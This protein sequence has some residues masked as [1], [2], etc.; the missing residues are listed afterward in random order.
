[1]LSGASRDVQ[2][3]LGFLGKHQGCREGGIGVGWGR[4]RKGKEREKGVQAASLGVGIRRRGHSYH[5][6]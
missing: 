2:N 1:M 3:L 6:D 5:K 4:T